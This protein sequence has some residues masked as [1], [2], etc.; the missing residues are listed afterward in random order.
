MQIVTNP[1]AQSFLTSDECLFAALFIKGF[2]SP[3]A[4][5][6]PGKDWQ[7][8]YQTITDQRVKDHL[9]Q[10]C[11]LGTKASWY[12]YAYCLDIDSPTPE[13]I[14]KIYAIFDRYGIKQ[15]QYLEVTSPSYKK[16]GN[17]R[18]YFRLE[19]ADSLPTFKLGRTVLER[20]FSDICEI[21]PQKRRK[22]RL[23]CGKDSFII[24][25][26]VVLSHLTWEQQLFWFQKLDAIDVDVFPRQPVIV[27]PHE[28]D[29]PA[30]T[31]TSDV[32]ELIA[33][34]LQQ[35]GTRHK[36]QYA[37]LNFFWRNSWLPENAANQV[38]KWIRKNHN[39][40][41]KEANAK[42]WRAIDAEIER[43][44]AWVYSRPQLSDNANNLHKQITKADLLEAS[45]LFP[46]SVVN[47]KSFI[48]LVAYVRPRSHHDWVFIPAHVWR[49]IADKDRYHNFIT[50]LEQRKVL[51]SN[52]QYK[53]GLFSRRFRLA[54]PN[55]SLILGEDG[56]NAS[57]YYSALRIAFDTK[58]EIAEAMKLNRMTIHRH[59]SDF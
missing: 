38:K 48:A 20:I 19:Y 4:L 32:A 18:I 57:D 6:Y 11:W 35:Y 44:T 46:N 36:A 33:H 23:P 2:E 52:R 41:S 43:Q 14:E 37:L 10:R 58:R 25:D 53:V 29:A 26:G 55:D 49:V 40:F 21:Y 45:R 34:G 50:E 30:I 12:P 1:A 27:S 15:S 22:D 42:N 28:P 51:E 13:T 54:L 56:R 8:F 9:E 31:P 17:F 7:T 16:S 3:F 47:Q 39:G 24:S 59:F 5:Q